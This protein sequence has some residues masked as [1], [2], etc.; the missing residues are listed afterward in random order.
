MNSN[1]IKLTWGLNAKDL[2]AWLENDLRHSDKDILIRSIIKQQ[3]NK[4]LLK[5]RIQKLLLTN[6]DLKNNPPDAVIKLLLSLK[7]QQQPQQHKTI[8]I[9]LPSLN[10]LPLNINHHKKST[11]EPLDVIIK[12]QRNTDAARRSR[13][14]KAIKMEALEKKVR[15]LKTENEELR[16]RAAVLESKVHH[17]SEKEQRN[18]QRVLELEAQLA[19]VHQQLLNQVKC[20]K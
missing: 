11:N 16:I 19:S 14:R 12:R 15:E 6:V 4:E 8:P 20:E 3:D 2:D 10:E 17:I 9:T 18:R 7:T 5:D 13:L 1:N